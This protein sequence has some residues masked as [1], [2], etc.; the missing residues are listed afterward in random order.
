MRACSVCAHSARSVLS[1][2]LLSTTFSSLPLGLSKAARKLLRSAQRADVRRRGITL[3]LALREHA[4]ALVHPL[5]SWIEVPKLRK[6]I[7]WHYASR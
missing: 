4:R 5:R 2:A 3:R 6:S 7:A 1:C